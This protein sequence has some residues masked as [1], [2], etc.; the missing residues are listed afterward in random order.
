MKETLSRTSSGSNEGVRRFLQTTHVQSSASIC[1]LS[2]HDV[3][4][5]DF[6][7]IRSGQL[8]LKLSNYWCHFLNKKYTL[9]LGINNMDDVILTP[10]NKK[11]KAEMAHI[12]TAVK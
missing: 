8:S 4:R 9:P 11:M 5:E 7:V 6:T 10:N 3:Q 12:H 1:L 2:G